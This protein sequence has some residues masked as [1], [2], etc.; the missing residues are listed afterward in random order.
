MRA[1]KPASTSA[2]ASLHACSMMRSSGHSAEGL[3]GNGAR[4]TIPIKARG[5]RSDMV[6]IIPGRGASDEGRGAFQGLAAIDRKR[7]IRFMVLI[8]VATVR[9]RSPREDHS[10]TVAVL[11]KHSGSVPENGDNVINRHDKE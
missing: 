3:P 1:S 5:G 8:R 9:E 10:L 7:G 4:C 11:I 2:R 6:A